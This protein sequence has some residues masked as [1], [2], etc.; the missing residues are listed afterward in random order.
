MITERP[1][2]ATCNF[3]EAISIIS[4]INLHQQSGIGDYNAALNKADP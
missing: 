1:N 3:R 2:I 4:K